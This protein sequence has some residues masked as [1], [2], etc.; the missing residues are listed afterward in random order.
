MSEAFT[1]STGSDYRSSKRLSW[2]Q[3]PVYF[4]IC[5]WR[6]IGLPANHWLFQDDGGD[7]VPARLHFPAAW[8]LRKT[9]KAKAGLLQGGW[10]SLSRLF[11]EKKA[12]RLP[13]FPD[14]TPA[15]A[16]VLGEDERLE[17]GFV[18][19][20]TVDFDFGAAGS[21]QIAVRLVQARA[22]DHRC[23]VELK[24]FPVTRMARRQRSQPFGVGMRNLKRF[25]VAE[26]S[27][28]ARAARD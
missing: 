19:E 18:D 24:V 25:L 22:G 26:L 14:Y 11:L 28:S 17:P 20:A 13:L 3:A 8:L 5:G 6:P 2:T 15:F 10:Q 4:S 23:Q 12:C 1:D 7:F 16:L 27:S 9:A 21:A